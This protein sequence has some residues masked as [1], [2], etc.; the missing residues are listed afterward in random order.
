MAA[1]SSIIIPTIIT[2]TLIITII[3]ITGSPACE[4][5]LKRFWP[6]WGQEVGGIER[7]RDEMRRDWDGLRFGLDRDETRRNRGEEENSGE[8]NIEQKRTRRMKWN[9]PKRMRWIDREL[10]RERILVACLLV[11]LC[12]FGSLSLWCLWRWWSKW[13]WLWLWLWL[14][15][16]AL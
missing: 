9:E 15:W 3:I 10:E 5:V 12:S 2:S 4:C 1:S 6:W 11:Y 16:F 13:W 14:W 7:T 8:E